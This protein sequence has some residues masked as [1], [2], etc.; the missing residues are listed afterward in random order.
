ML[1]NLMNYP[2]VT[3][4]LV[5]ADA[6]HGAMAAL[7]LVRPADQPCR[8]RLIILF[9]L[10]LTRCRCGQMSCFSLQMSMAR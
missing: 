9:G 2:A 3:A 1:Q 6:R 7:F 8:N 10:L 4:G 5:A